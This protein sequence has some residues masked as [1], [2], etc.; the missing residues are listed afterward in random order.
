MA[1]HRHLADSHLDLVTT[2]RDEETGRMAFVVACPFCDVEY[3]RQVKPRSRNPH[4]LEDFKMEI[5]LVAFDQL[6]YHVLESHPQE[7]GVDPQV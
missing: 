5:A 4:F 1:A 3:R 7:L 6:L 2:E